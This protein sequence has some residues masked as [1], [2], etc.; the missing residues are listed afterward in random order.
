[1]TKKK[2]TIKDRV[3]AAAKSKGQ[4][5]KVKAKVNLTRVGLC[6]FAGNVFEIDSKVARELMSDGLVESV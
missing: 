3:K 1:M 6:Y 4:K 5:T 2:E